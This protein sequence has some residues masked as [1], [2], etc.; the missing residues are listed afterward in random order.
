[1]EKRVEVS[2]FGG[3]REQQ[4]QVNI[5]QNRGSAFKMLLHFVVSA[6]S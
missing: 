2:L 4:Q 3:R 6:V 5:N 1:M